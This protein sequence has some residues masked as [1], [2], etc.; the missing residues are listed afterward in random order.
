MTDIL[1]NL[2]IAIR[3]ERYKQP[4]PMPGDRWIVASAMQK[5]IRRAEV[6]VALRAAVSLWYA[7]RQNFWRRLHIIACED[8]GI[9]DVEAVTD[10][11]TATSSPAWRRQVEDLRV[12]LFLVRKLCESV[13]SRAA[14]ELYLQLEKAKEHSH[15]RKYFAKASNELL[16]DYAA[17]EQSSLAERSLAV[18]CLA[19]TSQFGSSSIP[20]RKGSPEAAAEV[21]RSLKNMPAGLVESCIGVMSRTQWPLALFL[22]FIWQAAQRSPIEVKKNRLPSSP[23]V[24]GIPLVALDM[25][26]RTG[27]SCFRQLQREVKELQAYNVQQV[28]IATFYLEGGLLDK[29]VTS[30]FL[31]EL[32]MAGEMGDME[33]A[34]MELPDYLALR[35]CLTRHA[36]IL[37]GIRQQQLR[38]YL[39]GAGQ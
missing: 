37:T 34:G 19:G 4:K 1:A 18:W 9:G 10:V 29:T 23:A 25:F 31:E 39:D 5:A 16:V 38:R 30:P 14:D 6:E 15:Q 3:S 26:T 17:D 24:E 2:E 28:G 27:Q 8:V 32:K 22:P 11:L 36:D 21:L 7:E 33:G 20:Q 13:K 12:G 35:D